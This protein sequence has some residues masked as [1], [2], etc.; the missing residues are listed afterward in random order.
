MVLISLSPSVSAHPGRTDS[1]GGHYNSFTGEYH[2][3]H[4]YPEHQHPNGQCP[5][6]YDDRTG[7]SSGSSRYSSSTGT[8][9]S[10]SSPFSTNLTEVVVI[11]SIIFLYVCVRAIK[12]L[13]KRRKMIAERARMA[14]ELTTKLNSLKMKHASLQTQLLSGEVYPISK[15][16]Y[17][18]PMCFVGK[19]GLPHSSNSM[20]TDDYTFALNYQSY[21]Y[22][23]PQCQHAS[24][25]RLLNIVTILNQTYSSHNHIRPCYV[26]KPKYPP[27]TWY[28][29]YRSYTR[30]LD[31][32][33]VKESDLHFVHSLP[34]LNEDDTFKF[35]SESH[36][37]TLYGAKSTLISHI[38]Y[39]DSSS[40]LYVRIRTN[41]HV[42]SYRNI[43]PQLYDN[44]IHAESIGAFYN[45]FIK[46]AYAK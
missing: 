8:S 23:R 18:P 27:L 19:D 33:G 13:I 21:V 16:I 44:F 36:H 5:Y 20:Y 9:N 34:S 42:Y 41:G 32:L 25:S 1:N 3:H 28:Y 40:I 31:T 46:R 30:A 7:T 39:D 29:E 12:A 6:F 11:I 45:K 15:L 43:S 38:G 26:C 14:Q 24:S 22:H 17:I 10:T 35:V 2:Y 4:G 37:V